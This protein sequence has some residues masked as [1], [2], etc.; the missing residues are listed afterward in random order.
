VA[1]RLAASGNGIDAAHLMISATHTHQG[2]GG[3]WAYQG[4]ALLGGDQFDPRVFEAVVAGITNAVQRANA[5]LT[6]AALAWGQTSLDGANNNR[7][8]AEQWCLN[9]EVSCDADGNWTGTGVTP[10]N[11]ALT[12]IRVDTA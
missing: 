2:P 11:Q 1:D 7:R 3:F 8:R 5:T 6:P 12:V 4:Y 10:N 9:P